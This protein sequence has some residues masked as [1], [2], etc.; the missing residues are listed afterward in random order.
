MI[1]FVGRK[2]ELKQ[3][4]DLF[5]RGDARVAVIKGRRR[6]GKSALVREFAKDKRLL[7]VSGEI[8]SEDT[9]AQGEKD[10][11]FQTM[12]RQLDIPF[13]PLPQW[14]NI[15]WA[16]SDAINAKF[17]DEPIVIFLDEISWISTKDSSFIPALKVW[18]D[19]D[20]CVMNNLMLIFCGSISTWIEKNIIMSTA[21]YGR[22]SMRYTLDSLMIPASA[23]FLRCMGFEGD[24]QDIYR[25]LSFTGG[26]PFY[27][28][29]INPKL[30]AKENMKEICFKGNGVLVTEFDMIFHDL[31]NGEAMVHKKILE[32]L[33][34]GRKLFSVIKKE[35]GDISDE[36][37]KKYLDNLY[38][39]GFVARYGQYSLHT[40]K[41]FV[42]KVYGLCDPYVNFYLRY[43][44]PRRSQIEGDQ[45][46]LDSDPEM[47]GLD[48]IIGLAVEMLLIK[49]NSLIFKAVGAKHSMDYVYGPHH[50]KATPKRKGCQIDYLIKDNDNHIY[51]CEFKF[52]KNPVDKNVIDAVKEKINRLDAPEGTC[53]LPVLFHVGGVTKELKDSKFFYRIIDINDFVKGEN[54]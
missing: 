8:P 2:Q 30:T 15:F 37:L 41:E 13:T 1:K 7:M 45:Y 9:S 21:F 17:K 27:L 40:G 23:R 19:T 32:I 29:Q 3:L 54:D 24:Y 25:I 6:V 44:E 18:W 10:H 14:R 42:E 51:L 50:Q 43:I 16:I 5:E 46:D 38:I 47:A 48:G 53:F 34:G 35:Y 22:M 31:F 36:E 39:C 12:C 4:Q 20:L 28:E 52:S 11:F 49:N 33:G 26:V